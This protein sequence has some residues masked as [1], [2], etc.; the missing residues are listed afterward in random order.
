MNISV[1]GYSGPIDLP[2]VSDIRDTCDQ[3]GHL[4][5]EMGHTLFT[6]G[7]NGVMEIVSRSARQAGG[8]VIG[9]LPFEEDGN[10]YN[11]VALKTG[12]D[13][14]LRSL[15]LIHSVDLVISIGGEIGTLFEIV[16]AYG[17]EKDVILFSGTGGVTDRV[18]AILIDNRYLDNRRLASIHS[19]KS[20]NE[21]KSFL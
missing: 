12:M 11:N 3:V 10:P 17:Y 7:R 13:Y 18:G 15:I 5:A 2:P 4:I 21:L 20:L 14:K 8:T 1:I 19:V 16:A 6:G 9:V